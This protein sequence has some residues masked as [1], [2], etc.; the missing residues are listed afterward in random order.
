MSAI[1]HH[2]SGPICALCE[3]KLSLAHL[4]LVKWFRDLKSRHPDAHVSNSFRDKEGQELAFT[5]GMTRLHFPDSAHNK[6]PSMAL[7]I[8][9]I[10]DAGK[11][12][13]DPVFCAKVNEESLSLGHQLKWGGQWKTLGD[14]DH[15]E[16]TTSKVFELA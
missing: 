5:H 2:T 8:F 10:D 14:N 13:F 11:A 7:D 15:F 3:Y 4:D 16:M 12:V 9:Q 6:Q 1:P